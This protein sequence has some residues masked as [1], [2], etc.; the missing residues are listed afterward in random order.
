MGDLLGK[1]QG[2]GRSGWKPLAADGNLRKTLRRD[3][4]LPAPDRGR[5][6]R[7]SVQLAHLC[8]LRRSDF[9]TLVVVRFARAFQANNIEMAKKLSS[10]SFLGIVR[11]SGLVEEG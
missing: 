7:R 6:K 5:E 9:R 11:K 2:P 4:S 1:T 8:F 10:E 3:A